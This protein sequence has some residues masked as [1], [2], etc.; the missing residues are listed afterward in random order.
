ML[1]NQIA[2]Q[3][4]TSSTKVTGKLPACP[5]NPR[6]QMNAVTTRSGKQHQSFPLSNDEQEHEVLE[7]GVV[8]QQK[9]G[10]NNNEH[11]VGTMPKSTDD[12]EGSKKQRE[13][14]VRKYIPP[15][16]YPNRLKKAN[17]EERRTK[18]LN[19][20]KQLDISIP[21]L[22][23]I[24]EIPSYAKFLKDILTK[25]KE[26]PATVAM[27]QECS[28]IIQNKITP[29]LRD[30]GSFSIPCTIGGSKL[31]KA[32]CDL[33]A[34]VSLIPYS[35]C[36]KLHLGDPKPTTMALQLADRSVKYPIGILED[37]PI[38]IDKYYIPGDFVVLDMEEDARVPVI[39]GRPFLATAGAII[40]VKKGTLI[41]E[42][43]DDKIEFNVQELSK[44]TLCVLD[45][46]YVDVIDSC[47][48]NTFDESYRLSKDLMEYTIQESIVDEMVNLCL[49]MLQSIFLPM[50]KALK[51][52]VLN[53][54]DQSL[55][56]K[57]KAPKVRDKRQL[58]CIASLIRNMN[59]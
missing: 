21:L 3:A 43:G 5:E 34:S 41:L 58:L 14:P 49:E 32:L 45:G 54:E 48:T 8:K 40:N 35:L 9:G 29:K 4:S 15:V 38:K 37:V 44:D 7:E 55:N 39:L 2:N 11:D 51:F 16:P 28:A 53:L 12:R 56:I 17:M 42:I 22:D 50:P 33:G 27:S 57:G 1:E 31:N 26:N 20:I 46:Y 19:V 47:T 59:E 24:T 18:F 25:K 13:S 52:E 6:E 30:P 23:A 10:N 36:Q